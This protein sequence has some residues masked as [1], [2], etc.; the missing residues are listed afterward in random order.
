MNR[1]C[2]QATDPD[3]LLVRRA[4]DG[5]AAAFSRLLENHYDRLFR[6]AWRL[7]GNRAD[8]EDLV[9]DVCVRLAG[10]LHQFDGR[11]RVSTWLF[12]I[13][14]NAARDLQRRDRRRAQGLPLARDAAEL[15]LAD[16]SASADPVRLRWFS[17]AWA[18]V[19]ALPEPLRETVLLVVMESLT[20]AEAATVLG[21][22]ETTVSWRMFRARRRL[23]ALGGLSLEA[24]EISDD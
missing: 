12:R 9:Q 15:T 17:E 19:D 24:E 8:A 7:L 23:R 11:A 18:A 16:E 22:A 13:L 20:H 1:R 10:V 6:L 4:A 5:D 3:V 2:A 21:C 14:V